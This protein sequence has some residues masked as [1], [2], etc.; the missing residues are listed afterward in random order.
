ML[1]GCDIRQSLEERGS[2][3]EFRSLFEAWSFGEKIEAPDYQDAIIDIVTEKLFSGTAIEATEVIDGLADVF[4]DNDS[5]CK[6]VVI[7]WLLHGTRTYSDENVELLARRL[8]FGDDYKKLM[9]DLACAFLKAR[10][11]EGIG[12]PQ[13]ILHSCVHHRHK[14]DDSKACYK[15]TV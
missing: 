13:H 1:Y 8:W 6:D 12:R 9:S 5:S 15:S 4:G 3:E 11:Q 2:E 7:E 10:T 14:E